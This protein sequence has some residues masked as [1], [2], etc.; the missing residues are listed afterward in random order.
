MFMKKKLEAPAVAIG[1]VRL[2][3]QF[4]AAEPKARIGDTAK[5]E[6]FEVDGARD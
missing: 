3:A 2:S 5:I 1:F 4:G 6:Q